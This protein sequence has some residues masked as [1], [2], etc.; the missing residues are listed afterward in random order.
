MLASGELNFLHEKVNAIDESDAK[1]HK[2]ARG[3]RR[4]QKTAAKSELRQLQVHR[5]KLLLIILCCVQANDQE[6][7]DN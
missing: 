5:R 7:E 6:S 3:K 4:T 1:Y 2:P